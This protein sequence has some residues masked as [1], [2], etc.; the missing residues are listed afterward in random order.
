MSAEYR[1]PLKP[2]LATTAPV[3]LSLPAEYS[4]DAA[5]LFWFRTSGCRMH[6]PP[7]RGSWCRHADAPLQVQL[8]T[9]VYLLRSLGGTGRRERISLDLLH[10]GCNNLP[11]QIGTIREVYWVGRG[12]GP[13]GRV[14]GKR[15]SSVQ[16]QGSAGGHHQGGQASLLLPET[17][18]ET[19]RQGSPG[20]QAKSQKSTQRTRL[21][22]AGRMW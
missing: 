3:R 17:R 12:T 2:P 21:E 9:K 7:T 6:T 18:R 11:V 8:A 14:P 22:P 4:P 13:R 19:P 1:A 20:T 16:T 15:A 10:K 5:T